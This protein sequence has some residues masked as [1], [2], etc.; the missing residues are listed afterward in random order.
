MLRVVSARAP[1]CVRRPPQAG[2]ARYVLRKK[3]PGKVLASAHAVEREYQVLA[4]LQR[5]PVPVPAALCLCT[6]AAVLGTPFYV[7]GH[8]QVGAAGACAYTH[9]TAVDTLACR[10][11]EAACVCPACTI[12]LRKS[13]QLGEVQD[14]SW[15]PSMCSV[16]MSTCLMY[17]PKVLRMYM[18]MP[19]TERG[20]C[21]TSQLSC[22]DAMKN[23]CRP[24]A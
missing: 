9:G 21:G 23:I 17:M 20:Y 16:C 2:D 13:P 11:L 6:D 19:F 12:V 24:L 14:I 8:V 1:Q 18:W 5:T 10:K 7:M 3:P 4:A 22:W 15:W